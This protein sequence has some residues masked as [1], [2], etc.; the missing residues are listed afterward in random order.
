MGSE[1]E[2]ISFWALGLMIA[3]ALLVTFA[4]KKTKGAIRFVLSAIAFLLL[5]LSVPL[6]LIV[7]S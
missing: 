6:I 1:K 5:L 2:I 7:I 4:R 3:A